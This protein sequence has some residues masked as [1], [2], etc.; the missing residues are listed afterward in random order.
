MDAL[1]PV[2]FGLI[3]GALTGLGAGAIVLRSQALKIMASPY[4]DAARS[5]GGSD[6]WIIKKDL[7][8]HL[9]P[10]AVLYMM[11]SVVGAVVAEAFAS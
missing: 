8:P 5:A 9:Y 10:F 4:I 3:Y 11:L 1:E 6:W 7:L 2:Q